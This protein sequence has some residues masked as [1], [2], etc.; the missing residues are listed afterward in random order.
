MRSALAF[1][2][3]PTLLR[4]DFS[5]TANAENIA[6]E[7][8][9]ARRIATV[10]VHFPLRRCSVRKGINPSSKA[11][12]PKT[13][14]SV[15][16]LSCWTRNVAV[17]ESPSIPRYRST[18]VSRKSHVLRDNKYP[19]VKDTSITW[20]ASPAFR[21]CSRVGKPCIAAKLLHHESSRY[22]RA[23]IPFEQGKPAL[24]KLGHHKSSPPPGA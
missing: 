1:N 9:E 8:K 23:D 3:K 5:Q 19:H 17:P 14:C 15:S 13:W 11:A 24:V 2:V 22:A 4:P 16:G 18:R 12:L 6:G 20:V 21:H 10:L 7:H